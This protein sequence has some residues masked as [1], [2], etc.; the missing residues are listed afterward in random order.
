[1]SHFMSAGMDAERAVLADEEFHRLA[2]FIYNGYGIR[3]NYT[4]KIMLQARLHK[5]LR[6]NNMRSF[7]EYVDYVFS[8]A[9][10]EREVIHMID[11]VSTNKTDFFR[12]A[13]HF[14]FLQHSALPAFYENHPSRTFKVWSAAC[15]SGEEVYTI[16]MTISEFAESHPQI[17]YSV[18]GTD[19]STRIL[20][21]A[22]NAVYAEE[23]VENIPLV[24]KK[25]YF[26]RSINRE[27]PTVKV[28]P[29]LR[30]KTSY[31]RLNLMDAAYNVDSH[32]DAIFCR[33]V[34]IYFDRPTQEKVLRKLCLH[35][36]PGGWLFLG[37]S[38]SITGLDLPL[39]QHKPT[40]FYKTD[41]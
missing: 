25:K 4:K 12:E 27:T 32:F 1:M 35:L 34:L 7:R 31:Q 33:N 21:K 20:E 40:I 23:R 38:E 11:V 36:K 18:L 16:A 9:G 37:H 15:S 22:V 19:I 29:A 14:D 41:H 28:M 6:E 17:D 30:K 2:Q 24:L 8:P 5:R 13:A 26:L 39:K 10:M 3:L